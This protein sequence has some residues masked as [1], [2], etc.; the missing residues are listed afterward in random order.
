MPKSFY[1]RQP[2]Q[3]QRGAAPACRQCHR[4]TQEILKATAT[5]IPW[6]SRHLVLAKTEVGQ[7]CADN[8]NQTN[9]INN[10]IHD[11]TPWAIEHG[12]AR[13]C[14]TN[15]RRFEALRWLFFSSVARCPARSDPDKKHALCIPWKRQPLLPADSY[16]HIQTCAQMI[17]QPSPRFAIYVRAVTALR[18]DRCVRPSI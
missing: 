2:F 5:I 12:A 14:A 10:A 18:P 4:N 11:A 7:D 9:D 17:T 16:R 8:D 1:G 3:A 15:R 6:P 13:L